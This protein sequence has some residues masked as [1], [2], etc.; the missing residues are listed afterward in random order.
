MQKEREHKR[1]EEALRTFLYRCF[2]QRDIPGTLELLSPVF[3]GVGIWEGE[4]ALSKD[5]LAQMM[6]TKA[7]QK[8]NF[9]SYDIVDFTARERAAGCWDCSC[10]LSSEM[11][12]DGDFGPVWLTAGFHWENNRYLMDT[13]HLSQ[14]R[15][16][17]RV[18]DFAALQFIT[19]EGREIRRQ[20][21]RERMELLGQI[22]PGGILGGYLEKGLP[23][24]VVNQRFLD[25]TGYKNFRELEE[26]FQG[27]IINMVHPKDRKRVREELAGLR[28]PGDQYEIQHRLKKKDGSYLWVYN[29]GRRT[30]TV[31]GQDTI[32]SVLVDISRQVHTK[33]C[34]E[35]AAHTDPLTGIRN[36]KSGEEDIKQQ[37]QQVPRYL[38]VIIDLDKF[39]NVNDIYGHDQGDEALCAAAGMLRRSFRKSDEVYRLG[40]DEFAIFASDWEDVSALE[41]KL[42]RL[43]DSY[44][45]MMKEKW[46]KAGSTLSM[47][48]VYSS[49]PVPFRELYRMADQMLYQVKNSQKGRF[50]LRFLE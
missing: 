8:K 15:K 24:Y 50:A 36:R 47:G 21:L 38:F 40:G 4:R 44:R 29:I 25:M 45:T 11:E 27:V 35:R 23:L 28:W 33:V 9:I 2:T 12:Q 6:N 22:M 26:T 32:V 46:S 42:Q 1:V 13:V 48:G 34:L 49:R 41:G 31:D 7:F 16:T 19:T 17:L 30:V 37:L 5:T 18:G 43:I 20:D 39:K 10:M 3:F 14:G